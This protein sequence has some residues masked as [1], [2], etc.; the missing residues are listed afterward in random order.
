MSKTLMMGAVVPL[1]VLGTFA[2]G[3]F[4]GA[5]GPPRAPAARPA[6]DMAVPAEAPVMAQLLADTEFE[7]REEQATAPKAGLMS[8]TASP[9]YRR[10][11]DLSLRVEDCAAAEDGL[12]TKLE[13]MQGEILEMVMEGTE[14]SRTCS[15]R[16]LIPSERFREFITHLRG[17]G[18]VQSER[19]TAS[20]LRPGRGGASAGGHDEREQSLVAIR[21]A[22]E[23][24]APV[25]LESRGILATSFGRSASHF[26]K[27]MAVIVELTGYALPFFI[28]LAALALPAW[29]A[30]RHRR[31]REIRIAE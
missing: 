23:K 18:K 24:V 15:L 26:M 14:G 17:L 11:A 12:E 4:H 31:P 13:E 3:F 19:I 29:L 16:V 8:L 1:V 9:N 10:A 27:G 22:D 5:E 7:M 21:M 28:G 30:V 25:V 20:R 2:A 6:P